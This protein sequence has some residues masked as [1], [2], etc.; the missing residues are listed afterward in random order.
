LLTT[1]GLPQYIFEASYASLSQAVGEPV[2]RAVTAPASADLYQL[3]E[4]T[5]AWLD[6]NGQRHILTLADTRYPPS[7]LTIHDPPTLLYVVGD[8]LLLS[9]DQIAIVGSR[10]ATAAG[11]KN[12]QAFAADF[13]HHGM[14]VSSGLALGIDAAAH[15]GALEA[16]GLTLAVVGTGPDMVYPSRHKA[17]AHKII[18]SGGAIVSEFPLGSPVLP[19]QF[20]RRNRIIA[21]LSRGVLVV[22]AAIHSGSLITARLAAEQGLEVFAI[23]GSIHS[24]Q[25][26]GCHR[27]IK[28]G[29]KLVEC[30]DDVLS[31]LQWHTPAPAITAAAYSDTGP[32]PWLE[33]AGYDPFTLDELVTRTQASVAELNAC[34]LDW[35]LDGK[36]APLP[37]GRWQR[38]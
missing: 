31:E 12:A 38:C 36:L 20:P 28:D 19:H 7:L 26:K 32:H 13:A 25:T 9:R 18:E 21:G 14:V 5:Q 10:N 37:G 17:L 2:A 29:A 3:I 35:E 30:A 6:G 11:L 22:E 23:P 15:A 24:P 16:G 4:K 33:A 27:L 8:A 1:F 34:L